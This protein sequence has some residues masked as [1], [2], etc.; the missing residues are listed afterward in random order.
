MKVFKKSDVKSG[1]LL[2]AR[3]GMYFTVVDAIV[4]FDDKVGLAVVSDANNKYF[5]L[6]NYNDDLIFTNNLG[7]PANIPE[8]DI[9]KVWGHTHPKFVMDNSTRDREQLWVRPE[10]DNND[11]KWDE[12]TDEEKD[13]ICENHDFCSGCPYEKECD[14][15]DE[16]EDEDV[17]LSRD[18]YESKP[19]ADEDDEKDVAA[20]LDELRDECK[21]NPIAA[22]FFE[23]FGDD[24]PDGHADYILGKTDKNPER[25]APEHGKKS[26]AE[27]FYESDKEMANDGMSVIERDLALLAAMHIACSEHKD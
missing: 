8:Y 14:A 23:V 17:E 24:L 2:K 12:M 16:D 20:V 7:V 26:L 19:K 22:M 21:D 13:A 6:D 5:P 27:Q 18:D 15:D 25:E 4:T 1:M 9:V 10:P 3:N 11:K